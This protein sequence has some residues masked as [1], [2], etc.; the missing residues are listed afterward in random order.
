MSQ[1][2]LSPKFKD[3]LKYDKA[4]FECLEGTTACGKTT[5][6]G[7]FKFILM[8]AKSEKKYHV[9]AGKNTGICEKNIIN[10]DLG[11]LDNF[12]VLVEYYGHGR[13]Q[14]KLPHILLHAKDGDKVIFVLGYGDSSR[15]LSVLGS[16]FGCSYIDEINVASESFVQELSMRSDYVMCTLN[17][18]DPNLPVYDDYINHCR[19]LKKWASCVPDEIMQDLLSVEPKKGYVYW[20]FDFSDNLSLTQ[21][22]LAI[23]KANVPVGT[24]LYKNKIEGLRGKATGLVFSNFSEKKHVITKAWLQKQ[25]A[26]GS[27]K[28]KQFTCAV[29]TSYS[30]KSEDTISMI[31]GGITDDRRLIILSESVYNNRDL[32]IPIAPSDTVKK[33]VAFADKNRKDWGFARTIFIDSADQATITEAHKYVRIHGSVYDF[34]G[35]YKKMP[36]IDRINLMLG[37]LAQGC[38]LVMDTCT[39]HIHELNTYSWQEDK[40]APEDRNDHSINASQYSF[41]PYVGLIGTVT[42]ET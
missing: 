40:D 42:K 8:C 28:F 23:I 25:I 5:V 22:K 9:I 2:L 1:I 31:F 16:Q 34:V 38:Y 17:P 24:K 11:I 6:G 37:W 27:I 29:D 30:A 4:T 32:S 20:F 26:D 13:A 12:G 19:P 35:S 21:E 7:C 14:E 10:K 18:D 15:W 39:Y 41:L 36:I 33:M 3:F